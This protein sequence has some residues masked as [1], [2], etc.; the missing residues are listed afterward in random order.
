MYVRVESVVQTSFSRIRT[1]MNIFGFDRINF[2]LAGLDGFSDKGMC[3]KLEKV[4]EPICKY[5]Y[6]TKC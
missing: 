3:N 1:N 4:M 5:C 6:Y 2:V